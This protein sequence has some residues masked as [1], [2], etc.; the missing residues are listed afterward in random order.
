MDGAVGFFL[1]IFVGGAFGVFTMAL[2]AAAKWQEEQY[3][4]NGRWDDGENDTGRND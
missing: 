1:G 3:T 4:G 2:A